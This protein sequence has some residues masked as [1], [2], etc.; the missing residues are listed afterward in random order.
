MSEPTVKFDD[1]VV[2]LQRVLKDCEANYWTVD[3]L[4]DYLNEGQ[5]EFV[6]STG[7]LRAE[8]PIVSKENQEVYDLP[9]DC[10][11]VLRIENKEGQVVE[12]IDSRTLRSMFGDTYRNTEGPNPSYYYMDLDG[13]RRFRFYPKP[14]PSIESG[15]TGFVEHQLQIYARAADA[16]SNGVRT[17]VSGQRLWNFDDST[18]YRYSLSDLD[19]VEGQ[20]NHGL[21][22][23]IQMEVTPANAA[24]LPESIFAAI[25]SSAV[26]YRSL[27]FELSFSS[28]ITASAGNVKL[29]SPINDGGSKIKILYWAGSGIYYTR[30]DVSGE[31]TVIGS[32]IS[33]VY[34]WIWSAANENWYVACTGG[35]YEV[36][37]TGTATLITATDIRGVADIDGVIYTCAFGGTV[38]KLESG[39]ITDLVTGASTNGGRLI[40]G[41]SALYVETLNDNSDNAYAKIDLVNNAVLYDNISRDD[42]ENA[43]SGYSTGASAATGSAVVIDDLL[44][45]HSEDKFFTSDPDLGAVVDWGG[46]IFSDEL[47]IITDVIGTDDLYT[48][49]DDRGAI[50]AVYE[51]DEQAKIWYIRCPRESLIEIVD[52]RAIIDYAAYLAF[53][54]AG[55]PESLLKSERH[56]AKFNARRNRE[57]ARRL[58]G[59]NQHH[60]GS[61]TYFY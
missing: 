29:I 3:E 24:T 56:L 5:L 44:I 23:P 28:F 60:T 11:D 27:G 15:S 54:K 53:E 39:S 26:I 46:I 17:I 32:G 16:G 37:A 19:T 12:P 20:W 14:S 58:K 43:D 25:G 40:S 1:L 59:W 21:T 35:L 2:K 33:N 52:W 22:S 38:G 18:I 42:N 57:S 10:I 7:E 4:K 6:R 49:S 34:D 55:D 61:R 51:E 41:R 48:F 50:A 30:T 31:T 45:F 47:G 8:F 9:N 36:D 13:P